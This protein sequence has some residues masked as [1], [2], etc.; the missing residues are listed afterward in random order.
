M[1]ERA[2]VDKP[3]KLRPAQSFCGNQMGGL[4]FG[5]EAKAPA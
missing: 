2:V 5:K 3:E 1:G 4:E